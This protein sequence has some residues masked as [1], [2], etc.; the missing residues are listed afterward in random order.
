MSKMNIINWLL[1]R[2]Q[3]KLTAAIFMFY[4]FLAVTKVNM[5]LIMKHWRYNL[6]VSIQSELS[7]V[8]QWHEQANI[9]ERETNISSLQCRHYIFCDCITNHFWMMQDVVNCH[10]HTCF[11]LFFWSASFPN[12]DLPSLMRL[13]LNGSWITLNETDWNTRILTI[14]HYNWW[15]NIQYLVIIMKT[16]NNFTAKALPLMMTTNWWWKIFQHQKRFKAWKTLVITNMMMK[17]DWSL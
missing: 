6:N 8:Q 16:S 9:L 14:L 5:Y 1:L 10:G 13:I 4:I 3:I 17:W 12:E 11:D 2:I 7:Y 15:L